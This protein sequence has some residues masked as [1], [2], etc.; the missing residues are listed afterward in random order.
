MK[1][2]FLSLPNDH[3]LHIVIRTYPLA[4]SLSLGPAIL[5][6]AT[7]RSKGL[8]SILRRELGVTGFSFAITVALGGG[9]ALR[10][11]WK[12]LE[13]KQDE[14][15]VRGNLVPRLKSW[16]KTFVCNALASLVAISL[17]QSPRRSA[18]TRKAHIPWT[19]PI[20]QTRKTEG[21]RT[22]LTLDLTLLVLVRA[23]DALVQGLVFK[24]AGDETKQARK[25]RLAITTK[26]DALAFWASSAGIMWCFF[27]EPE[28]LPRS[29][30][31]WIS[32]LANIDGRIVTALR[33]IRAKQWSYIHGTSLDPNPV[34]RLSQDLGYPAQWGD[35]KVLPAY[36]GYTASAVWKALGVRG[37][38]SVGGLPCEI[39]HG[40]V[41]GDS[42]TANVAIRG[43]HAFLEALALYLPVHVLPILVRRPRK[44][45]S[46]PAILE[47]LLGILRSSSF[48]SAFV[49]SFWAAV[50]LT[51]TLV[52]ARALPKISHDFYD[53]PF[54]CVM[55][56]CLVCGG[57]IW[58]ESG[59]RRGEMALYV[60]PRAIRACLPDRW[61]RSGRKSA[62]VIER[63]VFTTSLATLLTAAV[64]HPETLRGLSRWTLGF[65]L[66]GP[67]A[68]RLRR[69]NI[70]QSEVTRTTLPDS[71]TLTLSDKQKK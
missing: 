26:L 12:R 19:V 18:Q 30:V 4:L 49:S 59:R 9:S 32:S 28:R 22:S 42:C 7:T 8:K 51:R 62:Y 23:F 44:L 20:A 65:I 31:K 13:Q 3:P 60:L 11:L 37:R 40:T 61:L 6:L 68:L 25:R 43:L 64:H 48:L 16:H 55:A 69:K 46:F 71:S 52:I 56:G 10:T 17:L 2:L 21:G 35:P 66:Q 33:A 38:G 27:Y 58:I 50:C 57:S 45:L 54:G 36:G 34:V 29:Y 70:D 41:T 5:S 47:T 24:R 1:S 15:S 39:V 63:I 53:G 14:T 67:N